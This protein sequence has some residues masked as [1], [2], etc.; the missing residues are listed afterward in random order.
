MGLPVDRSLKFTICGEQPDV[1]DAE[2]FAVTW[3]L[4]IPQQVRVLYLIYGILEMAEL[5]LHN[6][7][8]IL[9]F[10]RVVLQ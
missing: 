4:L 7:Q 6:I 2:K 10:R 1:G 8:H 9:I 5:L 3:L